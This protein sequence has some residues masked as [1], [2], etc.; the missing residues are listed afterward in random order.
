MFELSSRKVL[1]GIV[2]KLHELLCGHLFNE[3]WCHIVSR[4]YELSSRSV[5]FDVSVVKLH[6][7]L[8]GHLCFG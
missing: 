1:A 3:L 6:E 2:V 8:G 7:L 4:M 5:C